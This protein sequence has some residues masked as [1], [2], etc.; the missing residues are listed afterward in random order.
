[1]NQAPSKYIHRAPMIMFILG[2]ILV[3]S[4][5]IAP[6]TLGPGTVRHLD[7]RA[8]AMDYQDE[9]KELGPF[10]AVVYSFG[11]FNCHQKE[12]RTII[13]NDNQMPVCARDTGIFIGV[14]FGAAILARAVVDDSPAHTFLSILPRKFK[15]LKFVRKRPG[16]T[17]AALL[18]LMVVPTGLDGGIQLLSTMGVL[19]FGISYESTNP[20]RL[21][22]GFPMGVAAGVLMTMLIMTLVSRRDDGEQPLI[23]IAKSR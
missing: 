20:T 5:F 15:E 13:I 18:L 12:D 22:T 11:D 3:L 14:L 21:L 17:T 1:M 9:W 7:G 2:L 16:L 8:N 19:P 6:A 10:H 23:P 4:L